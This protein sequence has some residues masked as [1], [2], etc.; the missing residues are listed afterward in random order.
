VIP[1]ID[2]CRAVLRP[3]LLR[4]GCQLILAPGGPTAGTPGRCAASPWSAAF[5]TLRSSC[6]GGHVH[7]T[8]IASVGPSSEQGTR[9][10]K[11]PSLGRSAEPCWQDELAGGIGAPFVVWSKQASEGPPYLR[12]LRG[13]WAG[14]LA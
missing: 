13:G 8:N 6:Q 12:R 4:P 10:G 14:G 9:A 7:R 11:G 1:A 3:M 2:T 5:T